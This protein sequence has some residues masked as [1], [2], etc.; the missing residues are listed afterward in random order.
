MKNAKVVLI[1]FLSVIIL[2]L[3]VLLGMGIGG[4][5]R[6]G[7]WR[8]SCEGRA[9]GGRFLRGVLGAPPHAAL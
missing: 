6:S 7:S 1:I 3:C 4:R 9:A 8:D 2:G 5:M